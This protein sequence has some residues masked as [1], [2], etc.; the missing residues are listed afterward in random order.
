MSE[1]L[2]CL[3]C[4]RALLMDADPEYA[5]CYVC[6]MD[7]DPQGYENANRRMRD[8][9]AGMGWDARVVSLAGGVLGIVLLTDDDETTVLVSLPGHFEGVAEGDIY[10]RPECQSHPEYDA[11]SDQP[12]P[13]ADTFE[14][15]AQGVS[16]RAIT[17][18]KYG[19]HACPDCGDYR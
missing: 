19:P 1:P 14:H 13:W 15:T 9:L 3:N 7:D 10:V 12:Y 16:L 18:A 6:Q 4:D 17:Q 11:A 8:A 5:V 2:F